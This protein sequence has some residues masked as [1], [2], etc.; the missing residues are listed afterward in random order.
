MAGVMGSPLW[1]KAKSP[2]DAWFVSSLCFI[3]AFTTW[4]WATSFCFLGIRL[5][6]NLSVRIR[7]QHSIFGEPYLELGWEQSDVLR[8]LWLHSIWGIVYRLYHGPYDGG[9]GGGSRLLLLSAAS[10]VTAHFSCQ[11]FLISWSPTLVVTVSGVTNMTAF[12]LGFY[13]I[14]KL[15]QSG[16]VRKLVDSAVSTWRRQWPPT[17]VLLPGKSHGWRSL[18]GCSPWGH[19]ESD[20]TERLHFHFSLSCIGEGNGNPLQCSC[21]ENPRDGGAWWAAVC[22]VAQSRTRLKWL[23]SSSSC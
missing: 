17:P 6:K 8:Q 19:K 20:T 9:R 5:G 12:G 4:F 7:I 11:Y 14:R 2:G 1:L 15:A 13:P 23:S 21:L 3:L 10:L 16:K 22:G 18:V